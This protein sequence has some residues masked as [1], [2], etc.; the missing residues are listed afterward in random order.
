MQTGF[1]Y[2]SKRD[3]DF[4]PT[5]TVRYAQLTE[6]RDQFTDDDILNTVIFLSEFM[7]NFLFVKGK[8][9]SMNII[10]D[11]SN[12]KVYQVPIG[13]MKSIVGTL[14]SHYA[15]RV[16]R[17]F[18]IGLN[19]FLNKIYDVMY[20]FMPPFSREVAVVIKPDD[21]KSGK[22][23]SQWYNM[24]DVEQIF[25]GRMNN[26]KSPFFPPEMGGAVHNMLTVA[27]V[28]QYFKTRARLLKMN[29]EL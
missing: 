5:L 22:T 17:N 10:Q 13:L 11:C 23:L 24:D 9:E 27:E 4:R 1:F 29:D 2:I 21:L 3:K 7:K 25:G 8:V 12:V 6:I 15:T 19:Y 28:N 14:S 18:V 26:I 16:N 20:W